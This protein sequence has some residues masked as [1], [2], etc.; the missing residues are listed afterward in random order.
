MWRAEGGGTAQEPFVSQT[1]LIKAW[2]LGDAYLTKLDK[3]A[4]VARVLWRARCA[5][6]DLVI[7]M[8]PP[9]LLS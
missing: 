6:D 2:V 4:V 5:D 8:L 3:D 7:L 1:K 9:V